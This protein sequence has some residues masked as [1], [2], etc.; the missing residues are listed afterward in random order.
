MKTTVKTIFVALAFVVTFNA[1][2]QKVGYVKIDSLIQLMP[3]S[4]KASEEGNA[5]YKSLEAQVMAM[6]NELKTKYDDYQQKSATMA[7]LVK[8]TTEKDLT[9]L[10]QRIQDFQQNAQGEIQKKNVE[11]SK[12]ILEKANTAIKAVA[13]ENGY[14]YI[15]DSSGGYIVYAEPGDDVMGLVLKKLGIDPAKIVKPATPAGSK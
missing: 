2:A 4:Q 11:L 3:E 9:D 8:A 13:K 5:F 1:N 6:Q 14:R 7:P 10:Q 15:F 12:P